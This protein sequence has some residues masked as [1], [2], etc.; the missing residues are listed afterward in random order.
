[1]QQIYA[2]IRR[3]SKYYGQ[4]AP[5]ALFPVLLQKHDGWEY[6]VFGN[7]NNYRLDD[8]ELVVLNEYGGELR[9]R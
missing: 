3:Q 9:I 4:T 6:C 8:V 1:M 7:D 2:R 5:D